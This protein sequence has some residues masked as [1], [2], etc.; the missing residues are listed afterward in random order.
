MEMK[1]GHMKSEK[2]ENCDMSAMAMMTKE[3]CA[4]MCDS[5]E[6]TP[7]QKESCLSHYDS[8]G[9]FIAQPTKKSCC[10]HKN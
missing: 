1:S 9:K 8:D 10:N 3:E 4:K 5:L 7:E 2:M 6:C